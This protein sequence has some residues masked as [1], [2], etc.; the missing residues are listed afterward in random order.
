MSKLFNDIKKMKF[1]II[2][3]EQYNNFKQ[4]GIEDDIKYL[5]EK[6]DNLYNIKDTNKLIEDFKFCANMI[7]PLYL[8]VEPK[9]IL[10]VQKDLKGE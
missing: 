9:F 10:S 6:I 4:L 1:Q 8:L 3:L 5:K 7:N 2:V